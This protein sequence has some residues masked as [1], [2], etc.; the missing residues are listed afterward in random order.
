MPSTKNDLHTSAEAHGGLDQ[1][2]SPETG[3]DDAPSGDV[4]IDET[5]Q[6]IAAVVA[7]DTI[8]EQFD[9]PGSSPRQ[10]YAEAYAQQKL[11]ALGHAF[12]LS[13]RLDDGARDLSSCGCGHSCGRA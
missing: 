7:A 11:I 9:L 3:R 12:L 5:H 2:V 1:P 4:V 8:Q 10:R 13:D 6:A